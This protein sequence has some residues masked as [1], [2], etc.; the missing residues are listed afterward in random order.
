MSIGGW[1]VLLTSVTLISI[2]F[3]YSLYLALTKKNAEMHS[4][5][6]E[7]PDIEED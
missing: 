6:D 4:T 3:F 2:F 1:I 5:L 7:T